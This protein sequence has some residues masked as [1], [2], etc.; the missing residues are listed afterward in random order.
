MFTVMQS[1]YFSLLKIKGIQ[2]Q[3]ASRVTFCVLPA[4]VG[5]PLN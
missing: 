5:V 1:S 2:V 4:A 3:D